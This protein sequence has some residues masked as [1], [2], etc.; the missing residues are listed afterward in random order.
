MYAGEEIPRLG[1][2]R[3]EGSVTNIFFPKT[4]DQC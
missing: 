1:R 4:F 3:G 2:R